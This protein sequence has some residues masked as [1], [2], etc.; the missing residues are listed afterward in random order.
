MDYRSLATAIAAWLRDYAAAA[1]LEGYV[2]GL[3]GGIDSAVVAA[4]CVEAVG[5][6]NTL[7]VFLPCH[8]LGEDEAMARLCAQSLGLQL[9]TVDLGPAF[10]ALV[11]ALPPLSDMA[12][13]N[14]KPRLRMT[15]LYA[16]AQTRNALVA[17]TGNK[18]ETAVGYYTKFGDGGVDVKPLGEVY[19]HEVRGLARVLEVPEPLIV[20]PPTAGLWPGQTDEGELGL[21]YDVLDALLEDLE[22]GRQPA[23]EAATLER[24]Q[25]MM[26][27]SAH[28]RE[29]PPAFPM[30]AFRSPA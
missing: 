10:D 19:K 26:A 23:C 9:H 14:I 13:A 11:A 12:R 8:S 15:T 27:I 24:V 2:V 21:T 28:K 17:G 16:L 25:R 7:A 3:S 29:L 20:R 30:Q 18:P 5:P 6:S 22:H 4:L 1:H